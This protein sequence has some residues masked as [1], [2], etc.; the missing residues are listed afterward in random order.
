MV[1]VCLM[2]LTYEFGLSSREEL[3]E[4]VVSSLSSLLG[5]HSRLL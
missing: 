5:N 4:D 2:S 1:T 3:V